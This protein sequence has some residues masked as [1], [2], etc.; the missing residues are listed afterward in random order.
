MMRFRLLILAILATLTACSV[1]SPI[2]SPNVDPDVRF[3][4][5]GKVSPE[6]SLADMD[7]FVGL[8]EGEVFGGVVEHRVMAAHDG[9]MPGLVRIRAAETDIVSMYELSSFIETDGRVTYRNRHFGADLVAFQD[10][11]DVVDR[12]LVAM[13]DGAAYFHGITFAKAGDD[14]SVVAFILTDE[15]GEQTKH[16][17]NYRRK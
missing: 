17:V 13:T 14:A 3:L 9:N 7:W 11:E 1:S 6:A 15:A 2:A 10:P 12:P 5:E 8:W 4:T 16:I